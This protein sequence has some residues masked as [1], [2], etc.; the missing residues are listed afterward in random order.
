MGADIIDFTALQKRGLLRKT[1]EQSE[2][3]VVDLTHTPST[4]T[5]DNV[6]NLDFL[7]GLAQ[8]GNVS[9][10]SNNV[11]SDIGLK[12]DSV[13]NK[14]EDVMYKLETLSGRIAQIE[15]RITATFK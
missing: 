6:P 7:S 5:S 10:S 13:V 8:V 12:L 1:R 11:P 4:N 9:G 2:P 14:L 15:S 3:D